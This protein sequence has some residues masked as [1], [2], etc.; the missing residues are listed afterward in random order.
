MLRRVIVGQVSITRRRACGQSQPAEILTQIAC[1][2]NRAVRLHPLPGAAGAGCSDCA[3]VG[4]PAGHRTTN[5]APPDGGESAS[6]SPPCTV[7]M[8]QA[9]ESPNPSP[10]P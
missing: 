10:R 3:D 1:C 9:L 7:T 5:V 2:A 8:R 4:E 6:I